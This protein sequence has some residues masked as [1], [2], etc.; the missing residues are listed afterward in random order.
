MQSEPTMPAELHTI[1]L[2]DI[3]FTTNP[4]EYYLDF[5]VQVKLR[6]PALQTFI[7]ELACGSQ[8]YVPSARSTKGGGYGSMPASNPIGPE[9]GQI[10][11]DETVKLIRSLWK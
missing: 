9:G 6:S 3:V 4:F 10:L 5:G 11:A 7:V 1:R 2:G 8:G